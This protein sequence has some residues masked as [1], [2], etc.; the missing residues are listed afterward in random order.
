MYTERFSITA[1]TVDLQ[2]NYIIFKRY[3][4]IKGMVLGTGKQRLLVKLNICICIRWVVNCE[5][6]FHEYLHNLGDSFCM[7]VID[8][9]DFLDQLLRHYELISELL[10]QF[11]KYWPETA[12]WSD[13]AC[14]QVV[15]PKHYVVLLSFLSWLS[16]SPAHSCSNHLLVMQT[17][18]SDHSQS[19]YLCP[20]LHSLNTT[21]NI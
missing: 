7:S 21:F 16:N 19:D 14:T 15:P 10:R 8:F 18:L 1:K 5:N 3:E 6:N 9:S 11:R 4:L 12:C 20:T 2:R 13:T 17:I